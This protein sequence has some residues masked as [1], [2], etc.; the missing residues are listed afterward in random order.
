MEGITSVRFVG[1]AGEDDGR[2]GAVDGEV[3]AAAGGP[4][5]TAGFEILG[6]VAAGARR[7]EVGEV[8]QE[9]GVRW[10]AAIG[11]RRPELGAFGRRMSSER[12]RPRRVANP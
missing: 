7:G 9:V 2:R 11:R 8:R 5:A 1:S 3:L 12:R 4:R 10:V 6:P